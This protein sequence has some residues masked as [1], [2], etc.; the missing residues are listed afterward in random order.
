MAFPDSIGAPCDAHVVLAI[1]FLWHVTLTA[2]TCQQAKPFY[3]APAPSNQSEGAAFHGKRGRWPFCQCLIAYCGC[4]TSFFSF[5]CSWEPQRPEL[6][7]PILPK[8]M[9]LDCRHFQQMVKKVMYTRM[10][11][12]SLMKKDHHIWLSCVIF[13]ILSS[14]NNY[15]TNCLFSSLSCQYMW[16]GLMYARI[17]CF[18][19][20][21]HKGLSFFL[22]LVSWYNVATPI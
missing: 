22:L 13:I 17:F 14:K 6:V 9:K 10:L 16:L 12:W 20:H 15:L 4:F 21:K 2:S 5:I 18:L 19:I 11:P 7:S 3:C 1:T 8:F